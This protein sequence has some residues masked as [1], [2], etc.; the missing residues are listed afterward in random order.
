MREQI[1]AHDPG[2]NECAAKEDLRTNAVGLLLIA[3]AARHTVDHFRRVRLHGHIV[4]EHVPVHI[5][6]ATRWQGEGLRHRKLVDQQLVIVVRIDRLHVHPM[7]LDIVDPVAGEIEIIRQGKD[8]L[9]G[10][11]A[12]EIEFQIAALRGEGYL[13]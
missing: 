1:G 9:L 12:L 3:T 13:A 5:A 7:Q 8:R 2:G 4:A 10:K 6:P 11:V